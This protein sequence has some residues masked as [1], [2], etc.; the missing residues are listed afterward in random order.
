MQRMVTDLSCRQS[1][2]ADGYMLVIL[3]VIVGGRPEMRMDGKVA[4]A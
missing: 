2:D 4:N 1:L 3:S